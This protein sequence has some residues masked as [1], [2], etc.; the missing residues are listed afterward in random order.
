[1]GIP[2]PRRDEDAAAAVEFFAFIWIGPDGGGIAREGEESNVTAEP[3]ARHAQGVENTG[4]TEPGSVDALM[5]P[6]VR[7]LF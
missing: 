4:I 7:F 5:P 1:M 3:P 2:S 6:H